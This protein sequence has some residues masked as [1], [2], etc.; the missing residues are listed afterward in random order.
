MRTFLLVLIGGAICYNYTQSVAVSD[1]F[2][3]TLVQ[4]PFFVLLATIYANCRRWAGRRWRWGFVPF[5][6]VFALYAVV[7]AI[8]C[9]LCLFVGSG[10]TPSILTFLLQTDVSESHGFVHAYLINKRFVLYVGVLLL[11]CVLVWCLNVLLPRRVVP[12]SLL[13]AS[14][15]LS[16]IFALVFPSYPYTSVSRLVVSSYGYCQSRHLERDI[17][18]D[19]KV[20]SVQADTQAIVL[21]IGEAFSKHHSSLYGY[22]KRTNPSL[23]ALKATGNLY[24]FYDVM[25]PYNKTHMMLKELLS[26]HSVDSPMPWSSYPLWPQIFKEAGYHVSFVSNQVPFT[27]RRSRQS[28]FFQNKAVEQRCFDYRN[29]DMYR[30]DEGILNELESISSICDNSRELTILHLKGQHIYATYNFPHE[31]FSVFQPSDYLPHKISMDVRQVQEVADYDNATL[32]ND[33]V[34]SS[35]MRWYQ[36]RN[37]LVV[38]LSDHGEEV[39]DYREFLGRSHE[40]DPTPEAIKYQFQ[41]PFMIYV[42]DVYKQSN[43]QVVERIIAAQGR[44]FMSDDLPHMLLGLSGI[45]TDWYDADRDILKADFDT[46]RVRIFGY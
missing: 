33:Y 14:A 16:L 13:R 25:A 10:F 39:H 41:V 35:I 31:R 38:Y 34:V 11:V 45:T 12:L 23:E 30:Y 37:A 3:M 21:V 27:N 20:R 17:C 19:T 29:H 24:P 2:W 22:E 36:G 1:V 40:D 15:I 28:F 4:L 26:V 7:T 9:F 5:R 8:E 32:F 42:S 46:T 6:V 18:A 44:K 43:P